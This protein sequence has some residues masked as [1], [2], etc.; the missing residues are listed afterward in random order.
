M[1]PRA[2]LL[3][4]ALLSLLGAPAWAQTACPAVPFEGTCTG[5]LLR[6]CDSGQDQSLDCAPVGMCCGWAGEHG[7]GCVACGPCADD[8]AEGETGCSLEGSHAWTCTAGTEGCQTRA[9]TPCKGTTCQGG[10]C[11]ASGEGAGGVS[12][13]DS[14]VDGSRGCTDDTTA[15][16]CEA[17]AVGACVR[18][19]TTPCTVE[20]ACFD[21]KCQ[22]LVGAQAKEDAPAEEGCSAPGGPTAGLLGGLLAA[23]VLL[24]RARRGAR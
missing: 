1:T 7:Y 17:P 8:C 3:G 10:S 13:P 24:A 20:E 15:W 22:P 2:R 23:T 11:G 16:V 14:C 4:A 12:C 9:W 18:K 21:G 19:E 5:S 6:W